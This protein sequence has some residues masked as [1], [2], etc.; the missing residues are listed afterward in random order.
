MSLS[1]YVD[2]VAD[3]VR[4]W[5]ASISLLRPSATRAVTDRGYMSL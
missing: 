5:S 4:S 1:L 3:R 2:A